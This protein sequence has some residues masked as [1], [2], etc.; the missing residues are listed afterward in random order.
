MHHGSYR[1]R[2]EK[3]KRREKTRR[4]LLAS[5][6]IQEMDRAFELLLVRHMPTVT[7]T[8]CGRWERRS[9]RVERGAP[10]HPR[11]FT[12][13]VLGP[14]TRWRGRRPLGLAWHSLRSARTG[15]WPLHLPGAHERRA[16]G[17]PSALSAAPFLSISLCHSCGAGPGLVD[18]RVSIGRAGVRVDPHEETHTTSVFSR[19]QTCARQEGATGQVYIFQLVRPHRSNQSSWEHRF[20]KQRIRKKKKNLRIQEKHANEIC[21]LAMEAF[22]MGGWKHLSSRA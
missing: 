5:L 18:V 7:W 16:T 17:L 1:D 22:S 20:R 6:S 12:P 2:K 13:F 21:M 14:G 4:W 19:A 11:P 9:T 8:A 15:R 3:K 10:A